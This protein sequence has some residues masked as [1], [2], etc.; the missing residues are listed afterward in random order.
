MIP[1]RACALI[2]LLAA[3][4]HAQQAAA[5]DSVKTV[6]NDKPLWENTPQI[7]LEHVREIGNLS[8]EDTNYRFHEPRDFR[9]DF[10]GNL[11]VLD[12][13]NYRIQQFDSSGAY[14]AT[15]G[16]KGI[17]EGQFLYPVSF[18]LDAGG[19]IYVA[20]PGT[21]RIQVFSAGGAPAFA[22]AMD[23]PVNDIL[24]S[25]SNDIIENLYSGSYSYGDSGR[26]ETP[27][28]LL[29]AINRQG[30]V[31]RSFGEPENF[32]D[33]L[34]SFSANRFFFAMDRQDNIFLAFAHRNLIEKY[35]LWGKPVMIID[36]KLDYDVSVEK[37]AVER[38]ED[39]EYITLP[40]VVNVSAGIAVDAQDRIWVLTYRRQPEKKRR[41][42]ILMFEIFDSEGVYLEN[43]TLKD[44]FSTPCN[45]IRI[46]GSS[47]YIIE[48]Y[49]GM[50][51][52]EFNIV[53]K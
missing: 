40:A 15:I 42:D 19:N 41:E 28:P 11:Y 1:F 47:L 2:L 23:F 6:H 14:L 32:G 18:D 27:S 5:A 46:F 52:H 33:N 30:T 49:G 4:V 35:A 25:R 16:S 26:T 51:V 7:E 53:E 39:R 20:D 3:P 13:G 38:I 44:Y 24:L 45:A 43:I 22:V 29:R 37:S 50:C 8:H 48:T 31:L 17:D 36:R 21:S 9:R 10:R 34:T 12:A